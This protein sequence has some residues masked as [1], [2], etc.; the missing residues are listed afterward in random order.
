ML[1]TPRVRHRSYT[2]QRSTWSEWGV[3]L[4]VRDLQVDDWNE[5]EMA[6]HG[7]E[8]RDVRQVL[9]GNPVFVPNKKGHAASVIMI[10]ETFGGRMLTVPLAETAVAGVWRPATAWDSSRGERARYYAA[11]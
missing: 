11:R 6:R 7:V 5:A 10:G 3:R 1:S 2:E 8:E 9:A 4:P